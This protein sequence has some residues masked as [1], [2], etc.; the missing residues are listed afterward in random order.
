MASPQAQQ[1]KETFREFRDANFANPDATLEQMRANAVGF[2]ELTSEP[3]GV[4][5]EPVDAGG[6]PAQWIIP[7]G[8]AEDRVLQYVHGGGYVLMSAETHRKM[9]GHIAKATGCRA[10]NVDY[11]LAPE[12]AHPAAVEDSVT[13]YRWLLAQGLEPRHIA[14]SGDSAGG[15]LCIATALKIRDL[16]L[17]LP[18][19]I[20][21]ISPWTDM[22]GTGES[23]K[24]RA[25]VDMIV[26]P[27][28]IMQLSGVFLGGADPRDP[29][30]APHHADPAGLP[31]TYIQ[32]GDEEV[33]LDDSIRFA[34]KAKQAG[35]DVTLEIFPEMQHVFQIAA[36]NLP[37]ADEAIAKIGAWLRTKLDL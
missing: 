7:D 35:V 34:D 21:P 22:E 6:V 19:A 37:E 31:P 36:G 32:V 10:L 3:D 1:L 29:Y 8:A 18:A 23:M 17:P 25:D 16:D 13:A 14:I 27:D 2:G 24:T 30:A 12:H 20:V 4:R 15:G 26:S 28:A 11:R 5:S 9:V 33:L